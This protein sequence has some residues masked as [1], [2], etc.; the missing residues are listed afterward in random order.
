VAALASVTVSVVAMMASFFIEKI[1]VAIVRSR[2]CASLLYVLSLIN[3][4]C[5]LFSW[6][7]DGVGGGGGEGGDGCVFLD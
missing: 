6:G 4:L 1:S 3:R 5:L 2:L 7:D